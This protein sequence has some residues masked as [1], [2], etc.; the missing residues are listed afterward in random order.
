VE[1]KFS[2]AVVENQ[3]RK[4]HSIVV[5]FNLLTVPGKYFL[6]RGRKDARKEVFFRVWNCYEEVKVY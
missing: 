2:R 4:L 5:P 1:W 3:Y 6:L